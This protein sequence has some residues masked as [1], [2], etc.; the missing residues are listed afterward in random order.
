MLPPTGLDDR[1]ARFVA[2]GRPTRPPPWVARL[3]AKLSFWGAI[4]LPVCYLSLLMVGIDDTSGLLTFLGLVG[5]HL[6]ALVAGR[7]YRSNG[8]R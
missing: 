2:P 8:G 6:V 1:F 4:A 7:S 5:L 3:V